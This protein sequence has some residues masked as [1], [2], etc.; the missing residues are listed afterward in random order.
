MTLQ[1]AWQALERDDFAF[2]ER[3]AREALARSPQDG[4]ALYLLG[5]ALLFA[6]RHGE[7]LAP[8]GEAAARLQ[9]RGV[10]YRLGH[11][12]LALGDFAGAESALR[13]ET[14]LYPDSANAHNTLGVALVHQA[15]HEQA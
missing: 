4:E 14:E 15:K 6:G 3:A 13:R 11:C 8:L 7:A 5:S 10:G 2:A 1:A 9:R 12:R